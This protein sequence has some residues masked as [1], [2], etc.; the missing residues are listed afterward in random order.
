METLTE[1]RIK[2]LK[3]GNGGEYTFKQLMHIVKKQELRRSSLFLTIPNKMVWLKERTGQWKK[4]FEQCSLIKTYQNL[5]G[6]K[7]Q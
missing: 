7:K 6:E 1:R 3:S 5:Y 2:T 4:V